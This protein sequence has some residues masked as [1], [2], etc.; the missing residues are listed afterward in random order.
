MKEF[1]RKRWGALL[2]AALSSLVTIAATAATSLPGVNSNYATVFT[3]AYEVSSDKP[4]YSSTSGAIALASTPTAVCALSGSASKL[5]RVRRVF[6]S[7]SLTTA[8][9][10]SLDLIYRTAAYTA[11]GGTQPIIVPMDPNSPTATAALEIWTANPTVGAGKPLR[12]LVL[13]YSAITSPLSSAP[14]VFPLGELDQV[15]I[16]R[17]A[18]QWLEVNLNA[19]TM[20]GGVGYCTFEW[21]EE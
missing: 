4:T 21:T 3:Y 14:Y 17:S 16:L 7:A 9:V 1:L 19:S 13:A 20:T 10:E 8:A 5:I 12:D 18:N 15:P 6:W 11:G 2:G